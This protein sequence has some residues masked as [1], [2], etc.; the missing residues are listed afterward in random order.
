MLIFIVTRWTS[1]L[2]RI[3]GRPLVLSFGRQLAEY[4]R[5]SELHCKLVVNDLQGVETFTTSCLNDDNDKIAT[6]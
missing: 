4:R 1:S 6:S 3:T 2:A 5:H